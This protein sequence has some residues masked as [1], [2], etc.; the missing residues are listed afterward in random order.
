[1]LFNSVAIAIPDKA[2]PHE[3]AIRH[4]NILLGSGKK[5][6]LNECKYKLNHALSLVLLQSKVA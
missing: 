2:M 3:M 5:Q 4:V 1:M 6:N